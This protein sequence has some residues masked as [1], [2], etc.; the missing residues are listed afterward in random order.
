MGWV[1]TLAL[2]LLVAQNASLVLT[3]R[4]ARTAEGDKFLN[5]AAVFICEIL[6]G[7]CHFITLHCVKLYILVVASSF[8]LLVLDFKG[9]LSRWS[10]HIREEIISKPIETLKVA[11]PSFIY[12]LQNNLLYIA[13]SN[14]PAATF[15]GTIENLKIVWKTSGKKS[16]RSSVK[17]INQHFSIVSIENTDDRNV[18]CDDVK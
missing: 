18:F 3:M 10:F 1:K 17:I 2:V 15:Q 16:R 4:K 8:L 14:L 6:K 9:S 13:V 12:T 11:V 7:Y 5:T